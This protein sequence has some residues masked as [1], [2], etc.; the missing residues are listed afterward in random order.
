M[1]N[2]K[3][4]SVPPAEGPA[5][6]DMEK[7][8]EQMLP[9]AG[10]ISTLLFLTVGLVFFVQSLKLFQKDPSPSGYGIFPLIVS[11]LLLILTVIDYIQKLKIKSELD[12]LPMKEKVTTTLKY[13]FPVN[14]VV[15]LLMSIC[16]YIAITLGVPFMVAATVFLM[17]SMC[18]L[19]PHAFVKNLI[20]TAV[21]MVTIYAIFAILFK[22]SLP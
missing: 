16:F 17:I 8:K 5:E 11:G 13:L 6:P 18:Y 21:I 4:Q 2:R 12:G 1:D 10:R 3:R 19:I 15:F 22:V 9:P 7:E 20:Y 14:S